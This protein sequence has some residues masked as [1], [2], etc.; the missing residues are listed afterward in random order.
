MEWEG[1]E[2]VRG[3][4]GE[5]EGGNQVMYLPPANSNACNNQS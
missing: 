5:E 1:E 3:G 4:E 2:G